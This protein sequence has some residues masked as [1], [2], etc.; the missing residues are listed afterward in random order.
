ML[1]D[2]WRHEAISRFPELKDKLED[3]RDIETPYM[4]WFD[5]IDLFKK[6]YESPK[7]DTMI[8]RVYS[9]ADWCVNQPEGSTAEDDLGTCVCV[10]FYEEIPTCPGAIEEM[11]KWFSHSDVLAMKSTFSY[12]VG[13]EGFQQ[14]L[15]VYENLPKKQR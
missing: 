1:S 15:S 9:F 3:E 6:A 12:S 10:C 14:I 13:E 7:D 2:D 4:L 8:N 5:L 11:P